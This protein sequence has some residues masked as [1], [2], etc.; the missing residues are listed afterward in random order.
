MRVR[1]Y[2]TYSALL[3]TFL[4]IG[5]TQVISAAIFRV[6][7]GAGLD[8]NDGSSWSLAKKSVGAALSSAG[9]SDEIWVARGTYLELITLKESVEIYGGFVGS[10][11]ARDQRD[12]KVNVSLLQRA[13]SPALITAPVGITRATVLDGFTI[14]NTGGYDGDAV[15]YCTFASPSITNNT[16][17]G[18]IGHGI[19]CSS[20][21]PLITNNTI[22]YH[23]NTAIVCVSLSAPKISNNR[24]LGN[25]NG[26]ISCGDSATSIDNNLIS[27]NAGNG[28][29]FSG[30]GRVVAINNTISGNTTGV[31]CYNRTDKVLAN[32]IIAF[33]SIGIDGSPKG[34]GIVETYNNCV[35][36]PG[37][38]N[39]RNVPPGPTDILVDPEFA[40]ASNGHLHVQ[41]DSP[42]V[43][44]G[45]D[46]KVELDWTDIDGQP[47][48]NGI[49]VDVGADESNGTLWPVQPMVVRVSPRGNDVN[50]GSSWTLAKKSVQAGID[51]AASAGAEVWVQAALY[52]G[53]ITLKPYTHLFGGFAGTEVDKINRNWTLNKTIL[54]GDDS[55]T[56]VSV[57]AGYR[58]STI[59][60]FTVRNGSDGGIK[61]DN[62][63]PTIR[64]NTVT[65]NTD[66]YGAG[67]GCSSSSAMI[68]GNAIFGNITTNTSG[69][70]GLY[71]AG[72]GSPIIT[73]NTIASNHANRSSGGGIF[74][75]G[76]NCLPVITNNLIVGNVATEGGA[77]GCLDCNAEISNNIIAFNSSGVSTEYSSP[78]V[79]HD[80]PLL[81][82]N[83]LYDNTDYN[84]QGLSAGTGDILADPLIAARP[85]GG[86][87]IQ[88]NSPCI[89][90][91]WNDAP[92]LPDTDADGQPRVQ[93]GTVD[94][95]A[96]ESDGGNP[97]SGPYV[98]VHVSPVGDDSN[99]G[100]SWTSAKKTVQAGLDAAS[101]VGG[102]VW[103]KA[104][105]YNERIVMKPYAH[106]Y[107][108]FGGVE[109]SRTERNWRLNRT[110]IKAAGT[111]AVVTVTGGEL[112]N[113]VDGFVIRD[114]TGN[115]ISCVNSSPIIANNT[116]TA[117]KGFGIGCSYSSAVITNNTISENVVS[118]GYGGT[119][120]SCDNSF[121][122]ITNNIITANR[123]SSSEGGAI[124]CTKSS[125][126]IANNTITDNISTTGG[127]GLYFT[128][129]S[130]TVL[131]NIIAFN[132]SGVFSSGGT[133]VLRNN[134]VY[135]NA[136]Y[137]YLGLTA[138][139]DD[140]S[141]DPVLQNRQYRDSHIAPLS[142]CVNAGGNGAAGL[143]LTDMD[144]QPRVQGEAI[145]IGA[146]ES[147]GLA[148]AEGPYVIVRVSPAGDDLNDGSSWA[149]AKKTVQAGLDAAGAI[150]GEAWVQASVYSERIELKP[151]SHLYGGFAGNE[152]AR[153]IRDLGLN[154]T[155][156]DGAALGTVVTCLIGNHISTID[157]FTIRDGK[158]SSR[159]GGLYCNYSSPSISNNE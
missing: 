109:T 86:I 143:P 115:G 112:V 69:G 52:T 72:T 106:L 149:L 3:F 108:G 8:T 31:Y 71:C 105:A 67:I 116:V 37:G 130:P 73:N 88:A 87:H 77:I 60:G 65:E 93:G 146:D 33:N 63:S 157:G 122:V 6:N 134:C 16:I 30:A 47:R 34:D 14:R 5:T 76:F 22:S 111:G 84:Y 90:K 138:G 20:S 12:W 50:D 21:S 64:N 158:S 41:P 28:M 48:V 11:T 92:W 61:C 151:Y 56:V 113:T 42:C 74:C 133:P 124:H 100:S 159:G 78:Y 145:D 142:P 46:S 15:I 49:H 123:S 1:G 82:N 85:Y 152:T 4:L 98:I 128:T 35:Y 127:G 119:G 154:K 121:P 32:N 83:C 139:V 147:D 153:N 150:G 19:Y 79:A 17:T 13:G 9:T 43:D 107:G 140:I 23:Q 57:K 94:I 25:S 40:S 103:V 136:A 62:S 126:M 66:Y 24:I 26:G 80:T 55:G 117:N 132:S 10:E 2:R 141:V 70:G 54:D 39:Y 120:I 125:P 81:R 38:V 97:D 96:D 36:N 137:N 44:A 148:P 99:D 59:D 18:S 53:R 110:T 29:F 7:A 27:G 89:N 114:G 131:N 156:L 51:A 75:Q 155:I 91:G 95:G 102:D 104:G 101:A 129:S 135:E 58:V 45:L 144:G 118:S 68:T